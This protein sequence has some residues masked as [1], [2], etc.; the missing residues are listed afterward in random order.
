LD[1]QTYAS[2]G[3][4]Y[5]KMDWC[6]HPGDHTAQQ[7]YTMMS[8]S[9]NKTG[10]PFV[11]SICEWGHDAPWEWAPP[12]SN[13]WRSGPDHIPLWWSPVGD[14]D[15]GTAGGTA[16]IINTLVDFLSIVVLDNGMTLIS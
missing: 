7:L 6:A 13:L 3:V 4:D 16:Q 8:Q 11:F 15:P 12:I 1:A 2:W 10:H 14:Q 9:L 5:V